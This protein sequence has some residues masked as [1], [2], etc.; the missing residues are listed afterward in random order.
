MTKTAD[1]LLGKLATALPRAKSTEKKPRPSPPQTKMLKPDGRGAKKL[2]VSLYP[3]DLRRLDEIRDFMR[4]Q[5]VRRL[6]DSEALRL[7]CRRSALD[8]E[9]RRLYEEILREDG[10]RPS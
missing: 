8:G 4:R 10:R 6:S 3:H 5:G 7:A 9:L 2:S 1:D